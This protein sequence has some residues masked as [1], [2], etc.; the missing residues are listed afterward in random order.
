MHAVFAAIGDGKLT[1]GE[2]RKIAA[3]LEAQRK[4][5]ETAVLEERVLAL[6]EEQPCPDYSIDA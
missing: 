4:V 3:L 5:F 2:A 6:E 1:A